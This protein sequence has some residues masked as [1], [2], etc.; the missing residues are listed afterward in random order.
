MPDDSSPERQPPATQA[1]ENTAGSRR[2]TALSDV[3]SGTDIDANGG[4]DIVDFQ[5]MQSFPA[6]DPPAWPSEPSAPATNRGNE[7]DDRPSRLPDRP[8]R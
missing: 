5:S 8:A 7:A 2:A 1:R 6:S 4:V 3:A